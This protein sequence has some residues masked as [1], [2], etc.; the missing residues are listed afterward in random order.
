MIPY[1]LYV[2]DNENDVTLLRHQL[3]SNAIEVGIL[4]VET[5]QAFLATLEY[6]RPDLIIADGNV[7]GFDTTAALDAAKTHCPNVPFFY[8][9]GGLSETRT[10]AIRAAGASGCL[11]KGDRHAVTSAIRDALR[12]RAP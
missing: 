3:Q 10:A 2:E 12:G 4:H 6:V 5:P 11:F 8:L 1:I 9:T 7:P